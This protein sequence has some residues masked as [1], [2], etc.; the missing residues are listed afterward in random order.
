MGGDIAN[1]SEVELDAAGAIGNPG[2]N[3]SVEINDIEIDINRSTDGELAQKARGTVKEFE[4]MLAPYEK[5][6]TARAVRGEKG[7]PAGGI[8]LHFTSADGSFAPFSKV[9][10]KT[11]KAS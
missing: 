2:S 3:A 7:Y 10:C 8:K 4:R 11:E 5:S 6:I 1:A 9:I